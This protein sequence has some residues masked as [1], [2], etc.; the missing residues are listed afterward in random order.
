V[1]F[2]EIVAANQNMAQQLERI[3][4]A[5]GEQGRTRQ[6]V[7]FGISPPPGARWKARST[8]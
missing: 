3:G 2:N 1:L 6:R 5:V 4:K 7:K 8:A